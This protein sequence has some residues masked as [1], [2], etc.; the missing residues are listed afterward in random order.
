MTQTEPPT[1]CDSPSRTLK[2]VVQ[3]Q[4]HFVP[5]W[6][7]QIGRAI[8]KTGTAPP[9]TC[10][11]LVMRIDAISPDLTFS[12][13]DKPFTVPIRN[14]RWWLESGGFYA[15]SWARDEQLVTRNATV[16][17]VAKTQVVAQR[18]GDRVGPVTGVTFVFHPGDFPE[19]GWEFGSAT[20]GGRTHYYLGS[21]LRLIQFND[22]ALLTL[23]GG[24]SHVSVTQYPDIALNDAKGN[25]IY[26]ATDDPLLTGRTHYVNKPYISLG[27]GINLGGPQAKGQ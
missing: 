24:I 26:Y 7:S 11:H 4:R 27:L 20:N 10:Q 16:D 18:P 25:P 12:V 9:V 23:G 22:R 14:Q 15:Y 13:D 1:Q 5:D 3:K 17:G 2:I 19:Y 6:F 21:T 8:K